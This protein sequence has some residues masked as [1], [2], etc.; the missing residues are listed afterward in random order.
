MPPSPPVGG[1]GW[2]EAGAAPATLFV[3]VPGA[4]QLVHVEADFFLRRRTVTRLTPKRI[5]AGLP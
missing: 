5:A 1:E 2:G 3:P 4:H